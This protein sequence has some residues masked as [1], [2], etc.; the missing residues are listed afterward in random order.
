MKSVT[1]PILL[2]PAVAAAALLSLPASAQTA[3]TVL[4]NGKILTVDKDFSKQQV[5]A[6]GHG[7]VLATGTSAAMTKPPSC[8]ATLIDVAARTGIAGLTGAHSNGL[9]AS[10]AVAKVVIRMG[11]P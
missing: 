4:F 3:D 6:L 2:A 10:P 8:T 7:E 5:I 1:S 9:R 11:V